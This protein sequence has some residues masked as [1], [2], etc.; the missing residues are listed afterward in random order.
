MSKQCN[1]DT[2]CRKMVETTYRYVLC[3]NRNNSKRLSVTSIMLV[4]YLGPI[5]FSFVY[6]LTLLL[7]LL[8]SL[9]SHLIITHN[10]RRSSSARK[11]NRFLLLLFFVSLILSRRLGLN[12]VFFGTKLLISCPFTHF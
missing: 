8:L 11:E 2:Q 4:I 6:S 7:P 12:R 3:G 9:H 1:T 10:D 5:S